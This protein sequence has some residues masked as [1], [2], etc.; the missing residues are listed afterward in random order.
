LVMAK[1][2]VCLALTAP[3]SQDI[4]VMLRVTVSRLRTI[5]RYKCTYNTASLKHYWRYVTRAHGSV[6]ILSSEA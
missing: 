6:D 4:V 5:H 1:G 2:L 3:S